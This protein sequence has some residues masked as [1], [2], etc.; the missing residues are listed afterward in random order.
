MLMLCGDHV[1]MVFAQGR[2]QFHL[3]TLIILLFKVVSKFCSYRQVRCV[4]CTRSFLHLTMGVGTWACHLSHVCDETPIFYVPNS[5]SSSDS[6]STI[7]PYNFRRTMIV[8]IYVF[9]ALLTRLR[10]HISK[11]SNE[12]DERC[13]N[14]YSGD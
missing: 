13:L 8:T 5:R 3:F 2:I 4:T 10:F 7:L 6:T 14:V 9:T 12:E 1:M 11:R